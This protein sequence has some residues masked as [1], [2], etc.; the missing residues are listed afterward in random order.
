MKTGNIFSV[1]LLGCCTLLVSGCAISSH[2][3]SY[4]IAGERVQLQAVEAPA[5]GILPIGPLVAALAPAV[6]NF[7]TAKLEEVYAREGEKYV[8]T[9]QAR[10]V[11][12]DFYKSDTSLEFTYRGFQ[13]QRYAR[14]SPNAAE[15]LAS[16]IAL[17]WR[18]NRE[19]S[20]FALVPQRLEVS[21]AKAKVRPGDPDL[22]LRIEVL[23]EGFWQLKN[24]EIR[25]RV[26][27]DAAMLLTGIRLG[28]PYVLRGDG[29][30]LWL[31]DSEGGRSNYNVQ[32]GWMAPVPV[33]VSEQ[34]NRMEYARGNYILTITVTEADAYGE[35][36]ARFGRDLHDARGV[37]IEVLEQTVE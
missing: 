8:A 35:R 11:G 22:D 7:G 9:Y 31:E 23:L 18:S 15:E 27:G 20:L 17:G 33:S 19:H 2:S 16:E 36:V 32:T 12:E 5:Q 14:A 34:G 30:H 6:I 10:R 4:F 1:C 26:L 29:D 25:S 24:G 21:K 28:E 13:V 3:Q 37:L